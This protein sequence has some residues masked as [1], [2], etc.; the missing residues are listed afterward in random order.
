M[1]KKAG[2]GLIAVLTLLLMLWDGSN[3]ISP[4]ACVSINDNVIGE[5][6]V[7]DDFVKKFAQ[8]HNGTYPSFEDFA[9]F[10]SKLVNK[11]YTAVKFTNDVNIQ[12]RK[13]NF[14]PTE[15]DHHV[16][17]KNV[18]KHVRI[19]GYNVAQD[20]KSYVLFGTGVNIIEPFRFNFYAYRTYP[21]LYPHQK[22]AGHSP[23]I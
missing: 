14:N 17:I 8:T 10:A 2:I 7:L 12:E 23:A 5:L 3:G 22:P 6:N 1:L 16:Y 20:G 11:N 4:C 21:T 9:S 18:K 13:F 19:I 15:K